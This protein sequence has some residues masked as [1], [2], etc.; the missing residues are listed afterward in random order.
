MT[1]QKAH[2]TLFFFYQS[3]LLDGEVDIAELAFLLESSLLE[4][5]FLDLFSKLSLSVCTVLLY[6]FYL[7]VNLGL[8]V[9]DHVLE[10]LDVLLILGP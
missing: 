6:L 8:P 2:P 10:L 3:L 4:F 9:A 7:F 1:L 5:T